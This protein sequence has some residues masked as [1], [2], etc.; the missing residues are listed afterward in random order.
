MQPLIYLY[1]PPSCLETSR[2][3]TS[4]RWEDFKWTWKAA[5]SPPI[6][7]FH[8][9]LCGNDETM[10]IEGVPAQIL[11]CSKAWL[12]ASKHLLCLDRVCLLNLN[13]VY[14][15]TI[16]L[17]RAGGGSE[18]QEDFNTRHDDAARLLS[19]A[20]AHDGRH[21]NGGALEVNPAA[22]DKGQKWGGKEIKTHI[23]GEEGAR[24][25]M[26]IPAVVNCF[27]R[28][29][30]LKV[31]LMLVFPITFTPRSRFRYLER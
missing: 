27:A 19:C 2:E 21:A 10:N 28:N 22:K 24:I 30:S 8:I 7:S 13:N 3:R 14:A 12:P 31:L 25:Y 1:A 23:T 9:F 18:R 5:R 20:H 17:Q 6:A 16:W 15:D 11:S 29:F 4:E 26:T